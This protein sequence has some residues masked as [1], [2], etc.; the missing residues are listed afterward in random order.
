VTETLPT[1]LLTRPAAQSAELAGRLRARVGPEIPILVSPILEIAPVPFTLTVAPRFVIL[2]SAHAAASAGPAGLAGLPAWCVGDRTA[3]A[4]AEA[5]LLPR[6]AGGDAGALLALLMAECPEGPG[7]YLRGRHAAS[8]IEKDLTSAGIETRSV[9]AYDQF[10]RPLTPE[11]RAVLDR[12]APVVLPLFSP[13]SA[14]L[15]AAEVRG[16][17]APLHLIAISANAAAAWEGSFAS[18]SIAA[19]PDGPSMEDAVVER[20]RARSAC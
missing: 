16:A 18:V 4:A 11:A 9:I 6:S 8:D 15:L 13:R 10:P 20:L 7:L 1:I 17:T 2:T 14:R 3:E 12:T 5:G 19:A